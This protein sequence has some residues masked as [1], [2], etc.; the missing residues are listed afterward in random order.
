M[1]SFSINRDNL[2]TYIGFVIK[3]KWFW[4]LISATLIGA[5]L[6]SIFNTWA[7]DDPF[8]TYRYAENLSHGLGF[9]YNPGERFLST[10]TPLFTII[11]ALT[12]Y[13]LPDLPQLANIIGVIALVV[14]GIFLWDLG[15]TWKIPIVGWTGMLLYPTF[16][17]VVETMG[18]ETPLYLAFCVGAFAFYARTRY[19]L[20]GILIASAILTR[21]DAL[22]VP[23]ILGFDYV[24]RVKRP[25]SWKVAAIFIVPTLLWFIF[26]WLYFGD[27]LPITLDVKQNQAT[28]A[29]SQKFA[30]GILTILQY[31]VIRWFYWIELV[32]AIIGCFYFGWKA[33]QW[34]LFLLWPMIYFIAYALLGVSRYFWYYAPLATGFVVLVG[35]GIAA[36]SRW[37][38]F[39]YEKERCRENSIGNYEFGNQERYNL[40]LA[41]LIILFFFVFQLNDLWNLGNSPDM[42]I[43]IYRAAGEWLQ[44]NTSPGD[45]VGAMEVGIIGY[46]SQRPMVDFAGLIQPQVAEL[47][48]QDTTYEDAAFWAIEKYQP[49]YLVLPTM[50][51]SRLEQEIANRSCEK[52]IQFPG[53]A[54]EYSNDLIIYDCFGE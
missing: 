29:I 34:W 30:P 11:L 20:A 38:Q 45:K 43:A 44:V 24:L 31:Y 49:R 17:L 9:V 8:I 2:F 36:I 41:G 15:F 6:L 16:P 1:K 5:F 51:Y 21:P 13:F 37:T 39:V 32:V 48:S 40:R 42:R 14:G 22:L 26:A 12:S 35:L 50:M 10:T 27:P 4:M 7:Y 19:L 46:Y 53:E 52:A 23:L 54:Y 28:M 47:L 3:D 18:S 33:R 25:S